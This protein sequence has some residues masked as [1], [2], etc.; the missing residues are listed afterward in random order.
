MIVWKIRDINPKV[1]YILSKSDNKDDLLDPKKDSINFVGSDYRMIKTLMLWLDLVEDKNLEEKIKKLDLLLN[2]S[3]WDKIQQSEAMKIFEENFSNDPRYFECFANIRYLALD[4]IKEQFQELNVTCI[5]LLA[6]QLPFIEFIKLLRYFKYMKFSNTPEDE[7]EK[8]YNSWVDYTYI[9]TFFSFVH[10][11]NSNVENKNEY[12]KQILSKVDKKIEILPGNWEKIKKK[13]IEIAQE[14][15]IQERESNSSEKLKNRKELLNS[16]VWLIDFKKKRIKNVAKLKTIIELSDLKEYFKD[17]KAEE[18]IPTLLRILD[19]EKQ[20]KIDELR[21]GIWFDEERWYKLDKK[22]QEKIIKELEKEKDTLWFQWLYE[23]WII[24]KIPT[25]LEQEEI[26]KRILYIIKITETKEIF[27]NI[28][29]NPDMNNAWI[30]FWNNQIDQKEYNILIDKAIEEE[31]RLEKT[32]ADSKKTTST[33]NI[34]SWSILDKKIWELKIDNPIK[35]DFDKLSVW[36]EMIG[37]EKFVIKWIWNKEIT[38]AGKDKLKEVIKIWDNLKNLW[39]SFIIPYI[40]QITN[41]IEAKQTENWIKFDLT[42]WLSDDE[43]KLFINYVW[44]K[45]M[46]DKYDT[47]VVGIDNLEKQFKNI[48]NEN[49][50]SIS[51]KQAAVN[52]WFIEWEVFK[53]GTFIWSLGIMEKMGSY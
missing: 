48:K 41:K 43:K 4:K 46:W 10:D 30:K 26:K 29:K 35:F 51:P 18:I 34:D 13:Y 16:V 33:D 24:N 53:I 52:A 3:N 47:N 19:E 31:K 22:E 23:K 27:H 38:C 21:V 39:L 9:F 5:H 7:I 32:N 25:I 50:D 1:I 28:Q 6:E 44:K 8:L 14:V 37:E 17:K 40:N 12:Y 49:W 15:K 36:V 11:E 2:L 20:E 42:D 45:L